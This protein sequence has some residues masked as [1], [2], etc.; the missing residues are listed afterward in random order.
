[1][2]VYSEDGNWE[3][4][5]GDWIPTDKQKQFNHPVS[6]PPEINSSP[7]KFANEQIS[8]TANEIKMNITADEQY[9]SLSGL[10][11]SRTHTQG[12]INQYG[13][14]FFQDQNSMIIFNSIDNP[15]GKKLKSN[16]LNMHGN[17][18]QTAR[19]NFQSG[20]R[21]FSAEEIIGKML[22]ED[23]SVVETQFLKIKEVKSRTPDTKIDPNTNEIND[24]KHIGV[25][26][27]ITNKR[28]MLVDSTED[29]VTNLEY[30]N[31]YQKAEFMQRKR[32][33]A[34]A[35][36]HKI[37][38]DFWIKS[39]SHEDVNAAEFHF[40]DFSESR[41]EL[42]RFH[43]PISIVLGIFGFISIFIGFV[44]PVILFLSFILI[45][46]AFLVWHYISQTNIYTMMS[47]H[48]KKRELT[49][50]YFDRIYNQNL[51]L[52]LT[53]EDSQNIQDTTDWLRVLQDFT[54]M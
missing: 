11:T 25:R 4:V 30:L 17:I 16:L 19:N 22:N 51:I 9:A 43:H 44:E 38:H 6:N 26:A 5:D 10:T 49:I 18:Q 47:P 48:G 27:I 24:S 46:S 45:I 7:L 28:L 39:I 33:G 1:M 35:V 53:L 8:A 32:S 12:V 3:F 15:G 29:A 40:S 20:E 52:D 2:A 34:Y 13:N 21:T 23:E 54:D 31:A 36:K 50:G 41:Q 42:K 37:M 14:P